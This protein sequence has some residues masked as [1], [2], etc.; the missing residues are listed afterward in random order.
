[1][2]AV[3]VNATIEAGGLVQLKLPRLSVVVEQRQAERL[4]DVLGT[5][6]PEQIEDLVHD[7][8]VSDL[9]VLRAAQAILAEDGRDTENIGDAIWK[10]EG[11]PQPVPTDDEGRHYCNACIES[12]PE[13]MQWGF[14]DEHPEPGDEWWCAKCECGVSPAAWAEEAAGRARCR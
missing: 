10:R 11:Q 6:L 2:R 14:H 13:V 8:R 9:N 1:M 5:V 12:L 7:P 4:R 3:D